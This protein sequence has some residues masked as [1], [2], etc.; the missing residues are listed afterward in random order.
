M[1]RLSVAYVLVR[2]L[3]GL[4]SVTGVFIFTRI[5]SPATL[6]AYAVAGAL[7]IFVHSALSSWIT[8]CVTRFTPGETRN[9]RL[10]AETLRR[11][12]GLVLVCEIAVAVL[13]AAVRPFGIPASLPLLVAA[14]AGGQATFEFTLTW[15]N[16][17]Q[18]NVRYAVMALSR[19]FLFVS[20]GLCLW[21]L[22]GAD[23]TLAMA[24][25]ISFFAAAL[26]GGF[27]PARLVTAW[28]AGIEKP[29]V[30]D[31]LDFGMPMSLTLVLTS[32]VNQADRV[33]LTYLGGT[34][35]TGVY[36]VS[37]DLTQQVLYFAL[38]AINS[39]F[40]PQIYR[41]SSSGDEAAARGWQGRQFEMLAA[42]S[43][44]ALVAFVM[45]SRN[46]AH[47]FMGKQFS[48]EATRLLPIL[49]VSVFF[50]ALRTCYFE[51][52]FQYARKTSWQALIAASM[53]IFS[54]GLNVIAIPRFGALGAAYVSLVSCGSACALCIVLGYRFAYP[55]PY[56]VAAVARVLAAS[57]AMAAALFW[58]RAWSGPIALGVQVTLGVLVYGTAAYWLNICGLGVSTRRWIEAGA[59]VRAR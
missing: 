49:A 21:L 3:S 33:L 8:V 55:L 52:S 15:L 45:L 23:N 50:A 58:L 34:W 31:L 53:A 42:V 24:L 35:E 56:S 22:R 57:A 4:F 40:L 5:M 39:A 51:T 26:V 2:S 29:L 11:I 27:N 54:V 36:A 19:P 48:A 30:K 38:S 44:P 7:G 12:L 25:A 1:I 43:L 41:S 16:A 14:I 28:G 9:A 37:A 6:G 32:V 47:V 18:R 46:I 13:L 10:Y 59:V 17:R 20:A